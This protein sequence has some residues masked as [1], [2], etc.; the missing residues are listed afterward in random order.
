M[1][2]TP[3]CQITSVGCIRPDF[4]SVLA[5][6]QAA[7]RNIYGTDVYL[8]ADSQDGQFMAL[9]ANTIHDCNGQTL[10]VYNAFSPATAQGAGLSSVV[11]INGIRRK[12]ATYS[13]CDFLCVGQV[14]AQVTA[15]VVRDP[16]GTG[17]LL[18]DFTIPVSGQILVTGA[19]Q[20]IGAIIL[21]AGAVN[22]AN[23]KGA[24]ATPQ[25]GWQSA[26]NPSAATVGQPIETDSQL[27]QRQSYSVALPA[28]T[29]LEGMIGALYAVEGVTRVKVYENDEPAANAFNVP[30]HCLWAI[31]EGGDA[32]TIAAV[33]AA[34][35]SPGVGT[36]GSVL[37]TLT[38]AY[39]IPHPIRFSRSTQ[40]PVAWYVKLRPKAGYTL[41]VENAI[42]A[43]LAA[44]TN[45]IDI[46]ANQELAKAYP[47]ANLTGDARSATFEIV[48]L[49]ARRTDL[50]QDAYGD[51]QATPDGA[52]TCFASDVTVATV[53][54]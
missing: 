44:Y 24:I 15:G 48:G 51:I 34:K 40:I 45:G 17:W 18:P 25:L 16:N 43:A 28:Q 13:T 27:R 39:G 14:G 38:D 26:A 8:G 52:L 54:S 1:G 23:G 42:K 3:V 9:L 31:V 29:N 32:A 12:I 49:E 6:I 11:K 37:T 30:G 41:D 47:V 19:S 4:A 20:T 35:K 7:Y 2:T 36:Y 46:G 21:P 10:S 5:Y 53:T 50:S 33:I 22:T